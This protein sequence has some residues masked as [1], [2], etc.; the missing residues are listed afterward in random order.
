VQEK[1][2]R[3]PSPLMGFFRSNSAFCEKEESVVSCLDCHAHGHGSKNNCQQKGTNHLQFQLQSRAIPMDP[4]SF[5]GKLIAQKPCNQITIQVCVR[6]FMKKPLPTQQTPLMNFARSSATTCFKAIFS[7][8]ACSCTFSAH[9]VHLICSK[10]RCQRCFQQTA[11]LCC[12]TSCCCWRFV[13]TL[14]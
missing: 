11:V 4:E 3:C 8:D 5:T 1:E 6:C 7:C 9:P 14:T 2:T 13:G 10:E 12:S